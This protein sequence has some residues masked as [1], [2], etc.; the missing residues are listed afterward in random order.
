[1]HQRGNPTGGISLGERSGIERMVGRGGGCRC[2][3][4]AAARVP[5]QERRAASGSLGIGKARARTSGRSVSRAEQ[6]GR[7]QGPEA[8]YGLRCRDQD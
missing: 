8:Y 2:Y 3:R 7:D 5:V 1:M 4:A 6:A